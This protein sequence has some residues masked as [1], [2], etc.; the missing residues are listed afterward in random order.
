MTVDDSAPR[1]SFANDL[2]E[3]G[4]T[5]LRVSA[6]CVG[7]SSWGP[8]RTTESAADVDSRIATLGDAFFSGAAPINYI[9]TSNEYGEDLSESLIGRAIERAGGI[10]RGFVL[11]TKLDRDAS[12]DFSGD[13]MWRSLEESQQRLGID[14]FPVLYLHDPESI[15][16]EASMAPGG[17]VE[18]LVAMKERGFAD[19]IGISGGP[20]DMLQQFVE[21]DVFEALI[22]HNRFTLV[23]RTASGLFDAAT[24]RR[25]GINNAAPYG[26]GILTGEA[27][28]RGT[29]AYRAI[30]PAEQSAVDL[31]TG[32]CTEAGV[33][34]AAAALQFSLRE[35]RIHSTIV[36][37]SSLD[38]LERAIAESRVPIADELWAQIDSAL[39]D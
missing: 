32:L 33:S 37:V 3:F 2:V 4:S 9:D 7:T 28:F 22:T 20:V 26:G 38:G 29:Y 1:N 15:G 19:H 10:P 5:G 23:D 31:I 35:P 16:F 30:R 25:M 27:R 14:C 13:R 12:G 24:N 18:A 11:Q 6:L 8:A 21:T 17:P 34:L 39:T 36:G